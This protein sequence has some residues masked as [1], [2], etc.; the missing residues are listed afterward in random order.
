MLENDVVG[1]SPLDLTTLEIVI[2]PKL[3]NPFSANEDHLRY[4]PLR[5]T[6]GQ[7]DA[8]TYRICDAA[9]LCATAEVVITI[10]G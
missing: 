1:G 7:T 2:E 8:L 9:G 6:G 3:A 5:G 4:R 10:T